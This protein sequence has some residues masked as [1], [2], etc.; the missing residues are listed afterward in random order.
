MKFKTLLPIYFFV[1]AVECAAVLTEND[2]LQLFAKPALMPVLII[3]FASRSINFS[4]AKNLIVAAL[5]F[6]WIGDVVLLLDRFF[7]NLFVFGLLGFLAAH[8]FYIFYFRRAARLNDAPAT[9]KVPVIFGVA[10]YSAIVYL[11]LY[12]HLGALKIPVLIYSSVISLMLA[13]CFH[14][15]KSFDKSF[16]RMCLAG[17][18][19]FAASDTILAFNRFAAPFR[20]A[21][22]FVMLTYGIAQLL[23][24]EG[25]LRNLEAKK[26]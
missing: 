8:L 6:S 17:T 13:A 24:T 20:Y 12:A 19:I 18:I 21:P 15:F 14:A 2:T 22:F 16:A 4:S 11:S 25:S 7:G 23:I 5:F 1:L 9:P 3:Y 10:A 26:T